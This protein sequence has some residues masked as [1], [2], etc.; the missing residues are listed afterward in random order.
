VP[1]EVSTIQQNI[2][3][4]MDPSGLVLPFYIVIHNLHTCTI[5]SGTLQN[6]YF[7]RLAWFMPNK[8]K[9][10]G[11]H[12]LHD[13]PG[14]LLLHLRTMRMWCLT[15]HEFSVFICAKSQSSLIFRSTETAHFT[16][17]RWCLLVLLLVW[18]GLG[19][20][21]LFVACSVEWEWFLG[22]NWKR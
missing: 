12:E 10:M 8:P 18:H 11:C 3:P 14:F 4:V 1:W 5:W 6:L 20:Y 19:L 15:M 2:H 7:K 16:W 13:N 21:L 17:Y 9:Y 22:L